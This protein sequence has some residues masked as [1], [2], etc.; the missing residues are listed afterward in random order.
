MT[1][2]SI[3]RVVPPAQQISAP[4]AEPIAGPVWGACAVSE[5]REPAES[6]PEPQSRT[7]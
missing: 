3:R 5:P 2:G 1:A 6:K 7:A 4:A